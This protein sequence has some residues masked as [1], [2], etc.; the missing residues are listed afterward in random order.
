MSLAGLNPYALKSDAERTAEVAK[1]R[2]ALSA[3]SATVTPD[4]GDQSLY[5][6]EDAYI[7]LIDTLSDRMHTGHLD[8]PEFDMLL[9]EIRAAQDAL[10]LIYR[11]RGL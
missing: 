10:Y 6:A 3:I 5:A 11:T 2:T 8:I 7:D 4:A 1:R 9:P